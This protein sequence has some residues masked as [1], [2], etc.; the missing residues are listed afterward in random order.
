MALR[1][2]IKSS[3]QLSVEL[4]EGILKNRVDLIKET[5]SVRIVRELN[6]KLDNKTKVLLYLTGKAAWGYIDQK[7]YRLKPRDIQKDLF[8]KGGTLRPI[9]MNLKKEHL[10]NFDRRK[11]GYQIT[12][13][14]IYKLEELLKQA[15]EKGKKQK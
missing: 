10:I 8:M 5:K 1:D 3:A 14:G 11:G 7:E 6:R 12:D 13:F 4:I 15:D 9:L 2:L